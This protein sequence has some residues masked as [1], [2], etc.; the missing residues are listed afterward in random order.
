MAAERPKHPQLIGPVEL[1]RPETCKLCLKPRTFNKGDHLHLVR[2]PDGEF[3]LFCDD[4]LKELES[5]TKS[6]GGGTIFT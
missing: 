6:Y 1:H 4:C 5:T 2:L 3:M